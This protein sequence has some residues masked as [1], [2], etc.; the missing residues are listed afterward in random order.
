VRLTDNNQ[1]APLY[2]MP[3]FDPH[4]ENFLM[5]KEIKLSLMA[6]GESCT[7]E[8]FT[9]EV[10]KQK[11]LEMGCLP[12]EVIRIDRFA[13]FGCPMAIDLA[14]STLSIRVDEADHIIVK[15]LS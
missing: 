15:P 10:M 1:S 14:G 7:I 12:G 4:F 2:E 3:I 9:D 5:N 13:P 8:S 6:L 11:L